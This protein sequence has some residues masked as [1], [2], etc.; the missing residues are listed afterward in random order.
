MIVS[1]CFFSGC[2]EQQDTS[3]SQYMVTYRVLGYFDPNKIL[4]M[5]SLTYENSQ[6]GTEQISDAELPWEHKLYGMHKGDSVYISAQDS[7]AYGGVTVEIYISTNTND[8]GTLVKTSTSTGAYVI[9]T[10]SEII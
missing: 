1:I 7:D 6:G 4:D 8:I 2:T 3:S 5:A 9:A 10:A